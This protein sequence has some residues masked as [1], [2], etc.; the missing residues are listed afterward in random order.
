[1]EN[2]ARQFWLWVTR[3]D[4]YLEED[5]SDRECLDP[6]SC[7]DSDGWWTC[8]KE[9]K[10]GDLVFLWRTSPKK[11]IGYLIQAGSDAYSIVDDNDRGWDY[12]CDYEV[13]Y[14]FECP[15]R[16]TDLRNSPYFEE[17]G[18]LR[19]SFQKSNFKIS[20]EYWNKLNQLAADKNPGYLDYIEQVQREPVTDG[21]RLEEELEEKLVT[22]LKILT[23]YGYDLE[24]YVDPVSKQSGR[25][26]ICKG[27]GGRIDL[28]C[29]DRT[30]KRYAVI[31][32]KNVRAGQNTFGQIS[33][34]MGWV[35]SRIAGEVPVIGIVIS[36]GYDTRFESALKI[37][38][39]IRHLNVDD[40]GFDIA[41]SQKPQE[42][43]GPRQK[44][45]SRDTSKLGI[46]RTN[47]RESRALLK[48]GNAFFNQTKYED[49]I[50]CYNS[51][52]EKDPKNKWR[53][54]NKGLALA[55]LAKHD[56]AVLYLG[57]AVGMYPKSAEAWQS[58]G[59]ALNRLN[60]FEDAIL[61]FNKVIELK[62]K[63]ADPWNLKGIALANM[64]RYDEAIQAYD[65]A[66]AIK[67]KFAW[68][69]CN[70]GLTFA[71]Q[72]KFEEAIKALDRAIEIDP[73]Y[74][75]AWHSKGIALKELGRTTESDAAFAKA[76]EL[77]YSI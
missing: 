61:A 71:N 10:K 69:W 40:L 36:R 30:Q 45:I 72:S 42:F 16:V 13:L 24:L 19:C 60:K 5:G 35:Q 20:L 46:R 31:E 15:V 34:Y 54:I 65:T 12:G 62:P 57:K 14:K 37:T 29:I 11:D 77:G 74:A 27:N 49:A 18:P 59:F 2:N 52:L 26:F 67:P 73:Q 3:P 38:D 66:I 25:Q 28:L 21:I 22:N 23:N 41:A 33:N 43:A 6:T 68:A 55:E 53:L 4:Y 1:M 50:L 32:L 8:H 76:K 7:T 75:D 48:K 9:T 70:K 63:S 47:S 39:R 44:E 17:W 51:V 56:D 58:K 64:E